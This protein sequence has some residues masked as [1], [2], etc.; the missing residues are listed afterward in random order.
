M[1]GGWLSGDDNRPARHSHQR[2]REDALETDITVSFHLFL[3]VNV[4]IDPRRMKA[5]ALPPPPQTL[6]CLFTAKDKHLRSLVH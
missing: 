3:P 5:W 2:R 4:R 1:N 6:P